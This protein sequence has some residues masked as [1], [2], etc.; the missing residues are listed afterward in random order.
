MFYREYA[1]N[2]ITVTV[3]VNRE[4]LIERFVAILQEEI[5]LLVKECQ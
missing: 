5:R 1:D 4:K 2:W 3:K